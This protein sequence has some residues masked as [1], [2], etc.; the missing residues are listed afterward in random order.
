M[1]RRRVATD[2]QGVSGRAQRHLGRPDPAVLHGVDYG[3]ELGAH[4]MEGEGGVEDGLV[5][6][7]EVVDHALVV[8]VEEEDFRV[9]GADDEAF[10]GVL[11]IT[12]GRPG[13]AALPMTGWSISSKYPR[14]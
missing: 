10:Q 1:Q 11:L 3:V 4:G 5:D 9:V 8:G 12:N 14:S 7:A 13:Y 2:G 6:V